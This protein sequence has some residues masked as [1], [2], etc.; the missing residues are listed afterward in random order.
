MKTIRY[1]AAGGV[2][3]QEGVLPELD[4]AGP[5][6]LLLDRPSRQEVRL[7]KGHMEPDEPPETTALRET[8]EETGFA[9]LDIL[10]DLGSQTVEFDYKGAHYVREE[11]YFLMRLASPRR[12][13]QPPKDA[14]QFQVRWEPL[15][16]AADLLTFPA[17]QR[18]VRRAA[19]EY[20]K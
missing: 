16:H 12:L 11:H 5:H 6:V 10:A 4:G 15:H 3:V 20:T 19:E 7:P 13:P 8:Q 2:V 17:E 1:R 18:M 14:A 9:D